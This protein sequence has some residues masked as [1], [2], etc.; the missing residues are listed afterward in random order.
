MASFKEISKEYADELLEAMQKDRLTKTASIQESTLRGSHTVSVLKKIASDLERRWTVD[1]EPLT[2]EQK[3][4]ITGGI[5]EDLG[6]PDPTVV[7][8]AV[9]SA[10]NDAYMQM[11]QHIGNITKNKTK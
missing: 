10:S 4:L 11:V 2:D 1:Q 7:G 6:L 3:D 9:K 5:G 8:R